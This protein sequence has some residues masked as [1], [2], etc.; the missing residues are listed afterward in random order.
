MY[1]IYLSASL[2]LS[3]S[4]S[5]PPSPSLSI[6]IFVSLYLCLRGTMDVPH[7]YLGLTPHGILSSFHRHPLFTIAVCCVSVLD[8]VKTR[9]LYSGRLLLTPPPPP[10]PPC[11]PFFRIPLLL[12][13]PVCFRVCPLSIESPLIGQVFFIWRFMR[14]T[15]GVV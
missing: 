15:T 11:P 14:R 3:L 8:L 4:L 7:V 5:H 2:S 13:V 6:S 9:F 12:P 10:P 1:S